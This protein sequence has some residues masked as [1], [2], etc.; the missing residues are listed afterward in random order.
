[1][2]VLIVSEIKVSDKLLKRVRAIFDRGGHSRMQIQDVQE[3]MGD[4]DPL[5]TE[6]DTLREL[7]GNFYIERE[8]SL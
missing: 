3:E 5:L 6:A 4:D 7:Y 2:R 8:E 1:M